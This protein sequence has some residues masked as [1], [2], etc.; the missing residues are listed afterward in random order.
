MRVYIKEPLLIHKLIILCRLDC[1]SHLY[2][3]SFKSIVSQPDL[4]P[5]IIRPYDLP[6]THSDL[7]RSPLCM[8]K[9]DLYLCR[10][11]TMNILLLTQFY[12]IRKP[13]SN[14]HNFWQMSWLRPSLTTLLLVPGSWT[15]KIIYNPRETFTLYA[16]R[17]DLDA[18]IITYL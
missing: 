4:T 5:S 7:P 3:S 17:Q 1:G 10:R 12:A 18:V 6:L 8:L 16:L 14:F 9:Q 11:I 15:L 2:T 13:T